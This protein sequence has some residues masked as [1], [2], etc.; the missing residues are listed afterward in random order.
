MKK[1]LVSVDGSENSD[2]ALLKTK[3][4]AECLGATV[5][6]INVVEYLV[7]NPYMSVEYK[8]M[9][10]HDNSRENGEMILKEA[11]KKFDGFNGEVNTILE[12]GEPADKIIEIAQKG[13][14]DLVIM[15]SRGLGT[16]SRAVLGSVSNKV[17]NHGTSN[18]LTVR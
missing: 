3:D 14:Y 10:L 6:I 9:P 13:K 8:A 4:L 16:F 11:L 15:G 1:I 7:I 17:L 18:V 2:R 5:D 12:S